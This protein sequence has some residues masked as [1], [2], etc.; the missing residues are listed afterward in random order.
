[1]EGA[2]LC[3]SLGVLRWLAPPLYAIHN[4]VPEYRAKNVPVLQRNLFQIAM[5]SVLCALM[6]G[7]LGAQENAPVL[8]SGG[9]RS[10]SEFNPDPGAWN[11]PSPQTLEDNVEPPLFPEGTALFGTDPLP[12]DLRLPRG[13]V[14]GVYPVRKTFTYREYPMGREGL[15]LLPHSKAVPNRWMLPFPH[16]QRYRD[17]SRET[18]YMYETPRLWHPY[19]QSWLKGDL[20]IIGQDI[21]ANITAKSFSIFEARRL[22]VASG[23]SAVRPKSPEFFGRGEQFFVSTDTSLAIDVFRGET[24]FKPVSWLLRVNVVEN[25]NWLWTRENN[26]V[27]PD[28]RGV[29]YREARWAPDTG[30]IQAVPARNGDVNPRSGNPGSS[31]GTVNPGDAFNYLASQLRPVGDGR[32][33]VKVNPDT[34]EVPSGKSQTGQKAERASTRYTYRHMSVF[35][36]QEAFFETHFSDLSDNYDFISGR[37]GIQPFVSDFRGFIFADTNLGA[38]VF[39][40]AANNKLQYNLAYFNMREKDTYSELNTFDSRG[41]QVI[42]ANVYRQDFLWK[43]YTAELSFHA[44]LDDGGTRYDRN[45]FLVR[46][47]LLGSVPA[48][49][50]SMDEDGGPRGHDLRAYYLGW[51]GDGH[52]G[53]LNLTHAFYQVFGKDDFNALAGREVDINAQMA[54]LEL[55]LDRDWF[56][57]KLSGFYASG[58]SDPTDGVARGF[59]SIQDNPLFAGGPFSWYAHEGFNLAGTAVNLKERNSLVTGLRS[60]KAQGQANFVNPGTMIIGLGSDVDLTPKLKAF[61]NLNYIWMAQTQC[62]ETALQTNRVRSD[63]GLDASVGLKYRPLLT[64]NVIVSAGVG[65]FFPG[66]GYRD[67]Y[68]QNTQRVAGFDDGQRAGKVDGLLYNVF[69]GLTLTY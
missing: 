67:I 24:A 60:S 1:M 11:R 25:E 58:D 36:L 69:V 5:G 45:G 2:N 33:L 59:D 23:V 49:G 13:K 56:R 35:A 44:N 46:P 6:H 43:G 28:P 53:V 15:G 39:G 12:S 52:I 22:P 21:F 61:G 14:L 63:L 4:T 40:T 55:S 50:K 9:P 38:R 19:R 10:P 7:H 16:W 17:P 30:K 47:A 32:E 18:P 68:R 27:D 29:G 31:N 64:D 42:I 65:F 54:A 34:Q 51:A 57:V 41:Q 3:G 37:T 62:I 20:P 66:G 8:P 48:D 26:L